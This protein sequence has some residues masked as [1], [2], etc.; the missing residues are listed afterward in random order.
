MRSSC[1]EFAGGLLVIGGGIIGLEMACVYDALGTR[2]SVVE[3]TADADARLRSG[4]GAPARE[5][6]PRPL[7]GDPARHQGDGHRG[8]AAAGLKV[9]FAGEKA[10]GAADLRA[11]AG[12]RRA[13]C[14]T[15]RRSPR[16]VAGVNGLRARLHPGRP[17]D[18]HQRAAHLRD[19][20]HRRRRR[21]W[22][23]R[24]CTRARWP[25]RWPPATRARSMR[26]SSP[27]SPTPTRRSP[28]SDSPRPRRAPRASR[29]RRAP[30]PGWRTGARCRSGA[31]KASPSCCS[32]RRRTA[33]SAAGIVGTN[34]GELIS[35][36]ALAIETGCDAADIGLTIHPHPTLSET[37]AGAAEAFEGTLTDLYIPKR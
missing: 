37:V 35:E 3:L 4:P 17:A 19:R 15:A 27:R 14:R 28:G 23:T 26:A 30:F 2:V 16:S 13:A 7:R 20:R 21:C 36:V 1:R 11:R 6:H 12:R 29:S 10:P 25:R 33:C 9:S 34:A 32:I 18:A 24:R 8:P 31:R 5:A 22:R